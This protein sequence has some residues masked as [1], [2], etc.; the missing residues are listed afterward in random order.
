[1]YEHNYELD[2]IEIRFKRKSDGREIAAD[3][4]LKNSQLN[5][6]LFIECKDGGLDLDQA[7]RYN[8]LT[9]SDILT[10]QITN[11]VGDIKHEIAYIGSKQKKDKLI[12]DIKFSSLKFPILINEES[13]ITLEY[14]KFVCPTLEEIFSNEVSIK[15]YS[16]NYYPF[17]VND[18]DEYI[19]SIIT[20]TLM[21]FMGM[22]K[23]FSPED[24]LNETHSIFNYIGTLTIN[25]LKR[26]IGILLSNLSKKELNKF[27][28]MPTTK[29][30]FKLK[31]KGSIGLRK[32]I[33]KYIAS[34]LEIKTRPRR[35]KSLFDF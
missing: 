25:E 7:N 20:P 8:T 10:S 1:M 16:L 6:L 3:I 35:Q 18:S 13:K 5:S 12:T 24:I 15:N 4:L 19:L 27:F 21:K 26:K 33:E 11:L 28:E 14:N 29:T 32:E 23:E 17:G 22:Q 30:N 31:S 34:Q 9:D 2:T